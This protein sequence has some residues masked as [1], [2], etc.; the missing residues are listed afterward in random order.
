MSSVLTFAHIIIKGCAQYILGAQGGTLE[1][2][3]GK[4]KSSMSLQEFPKSFQL[5]EKR[6]GL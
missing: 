1:E 2:Q 4:A 6:C 3:L 5:E